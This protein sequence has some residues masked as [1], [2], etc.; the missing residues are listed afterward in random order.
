ME[1][2]LTQNNYKNKCEEN[3]EKREE[4]EKCQ[5]VE[6]KKKEDNETKVNAKKEN[7]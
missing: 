4:L 2:N 7:L 3:F 5:K 6:Q 1:N